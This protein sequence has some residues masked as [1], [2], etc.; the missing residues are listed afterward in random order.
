MLRL[1]AALFVA[2]LLLG[3]CTAADGPVT[4]P[5]AEPV[6]DSAAAVAIE[7]AAAV[8]GA[9]EV[10]W[11]YRLE[12]G[13]VFRVRRQQTS[14]N[15]TGAPLFFEGDDE[16][17]VE[18]EKVDANGTMTVTMTTIR[19][20]MREQTGPE[21][22]LVK[23]KYADR[24]PK[25]RAIVDRQG[26]VLGG[27]ILVDTDEH[28]AW[29]VAASQP[30]SQTHVRSDS[31]LV[32]LEADDILPRLPGPARMRLGQTYRDTVREVRRSRMIKLDTSDRAE[33][34]P[35]ATKRSP[36]GEEQVVT[37]TETTIET[38]TPIGWIE[39]EGK[40]YLK[41][42]ATFYRHE[43]LPGGMTFEWMHDTDY[44]IRDDGLI[45]RAETH[46]TKRRDGEHEGE[47]EEVM[48]LLEE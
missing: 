28:R 48:E 11:G 14:S 30:G 3:A 21:H 32:A 23:S 43:P 7:R 26:N 45:V 42:A 33:P 37:F 31:S 41:V 19:N 2:S 40:R 35:G 9:A 25:I 10:E 22:P 46:G 44:L 24:T 17:L 27:E 4:L 29:K 1:S 38:F 5:D 12:A 6:I 36:F 47:R 39:H 34:R 16:V 20:V 15:R 8:T 13:D 18:V